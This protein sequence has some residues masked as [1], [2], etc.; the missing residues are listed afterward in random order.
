MTGQEDRY[1]AA[2]IGGGLTGLTAAVW[3]LGDSRVSP[4]H[5]NI[6]DKIA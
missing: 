2:V 6:P 1:E 5:Y 3:L 4:L